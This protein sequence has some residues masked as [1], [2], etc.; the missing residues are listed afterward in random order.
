MHSQ[1]TL[2]QILQS[3]V[4]HQ[5]T[6]VVSKAAA[7]LSVQKVIQDVRVGNAVKSMKVGVV[8]AHALHTAVVGKHVQLLMT[9]PI[10]QFA[11]VVHV[12]QR[13]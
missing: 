7:K 8:M 4:V 10:T 2:L 6:N 11:V 13:V 12:I 5:V 9:L 1:K 3:H